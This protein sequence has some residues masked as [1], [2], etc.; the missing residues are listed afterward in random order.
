MNDIAISCPL[1]NLSFGNI[2]YNILR[3]IYLRDLNVCLF[4]VSNQVDL[5]SFDRTLKDFAEWVQSSI[6]NRYKKL[7]NDTPFLNIWHIQGAEATISK[8]SVLYTFHETSEATQ[9]EINICNLYKKVLF[10]SA[11]SDQVFKEQGLMNSD[12]ANPGF[13]RDFFENDSFKLKN[14]IHFGIMGKWEQR[15]HTEK[16]INI[17]SSVYGNDHNYQLSCCVDNRFLDQSALNNSKVQYSRFTNINFIPFVPKNSQVNQ[18]LNSI[19]IDLGGMS[20]AEGWNLPS[21]NAV[22]LGK[23]SIVLNCS[24][25]KDW[26]TKEN[27]ILVEPS[28]KQPIY[29]N[30]FFK[31]ENEFNSGD[32]YIF[33][34][35]DL[36]SAMNKAVDKVKDK[37]K[38]HAGLKLKEAFSYK[39]TVDNI[40]KHFDKPPQST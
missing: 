20:G 27:S 39:N 35:Q 24:A 11:Y 38:N 34:D 30:I 31:R 23:W 32:K 14:K 6:F 26:A 16:I 5:S 25:H 29:D 8:N 19:D 22:C 33:A 4:P 28:G 2:S 18:F 15:K 36:I 3:E 9:S 12:Y 13:D 10:S 17:W 37:E 1:N 7:S 21:F 40:L